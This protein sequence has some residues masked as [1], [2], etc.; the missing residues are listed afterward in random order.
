MFIVLYISLG[1]EKDKQ[2]LEV[3]GTT[4]KMRNIKQEG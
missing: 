3:C 2:T 4:S 1:E